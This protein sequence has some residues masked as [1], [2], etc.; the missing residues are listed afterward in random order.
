[1]YTLVTGATG[2]IGKRLVKRLIEEGR[3]V[4]CL[5]RK[6]S[7]LSDLNGMNLK[8]IY[9]DLLAPNTYC[10]ELF[11]VNVVYH[12]AANSKPSTNKTLD[13]YRVNY[14]G[15]EFLLQIIYKNASQIKKVIIMSSIAATGPSISGELLNE[16]SPCFP[17]TMYGKSK[18]IVEEIAKKYV[19]KYSLPIVVLRPPMVY[20]IGDADWIPFFKMIKSASATNK[21]V[22]LPGN[23]LNKID[24]CYVDNLIDAMILAEISDKTV[25]QVYFVSDNKSYKILEIVNAVCDAYEIPVPK[26]YYSKKFCYIIS[27]VC[28]L[29]SRIF[30]KEMPVSLRE[31]NWMTRDYWVCDI[32]KFKNDTGYSSK[33]KLEDGIAKTIETLEESYEDYK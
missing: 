28:D 24:F 18:V 7:D 9:G 2:F 20:G 31:F 8:I 12:L 22:F 23:H 3:K 26:K 27:L 19:E 32:T 6:T 30:K 33:V 25:G 15:T 1:M 29:I 17:I 16:M 10:D 13:E 11:D 14:D 21:K 4:K 5:V